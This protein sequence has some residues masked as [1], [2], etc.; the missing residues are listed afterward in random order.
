MKNITGRIIMPL[1]SLIILSGVWITGCKKSEDPIKFP[2]G[3]FPDT[4][5]SLT[6]INSPYDDYNLDIYKLSADVPLI[7]SSN[8]KSLGGQ[9]DLEQAML[10][11]QFDQETGAFDF[12]AEMLDDIFFDNLINKA[13]TARNDF[14]PYR[15]YSAYDGNE[16]FI[17][18][19][20]NAN[21]DL[22]MFYLK[23]RPVF[24]S[25]LPDIYGP[26]PITL[27]NSSHNEA[28]LSFN[29]DLDT[30]YFISDATGDF[31]IYMI[32]AP[33]ETTL[34]SWFNSP[35]SSGS[36]P[37][38]S[39]NSTSD[40]KCPIRFRNFMIF[41]SNRPGGLGGFD[42]YYSIFKN[43][44]WGSPVNFGPGINSSSDEYR[45]VVGFHPDFTNLFMMFSSNRPGGK[46]GFD[47][48]F[49]GFEIP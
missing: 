42:L 35:Y 25:S 18:S 1:I 12:N 48:Y 15:L 24:S 28:Y 39:I 44:K 31:D 17:I 32:A 13:K 40:D 8:R 29:P 4:V 33:E 21:G 26:F 46:G 22:D 14:G 34:T 45:P 11:F 9:F 43:G 49:T 27:L 2:T 38:D 5:R 6:G 23:N 41:T 36:V 16:Y 20:E 3:T 30:A 19:S 7:F 10:T 37:L 47:L